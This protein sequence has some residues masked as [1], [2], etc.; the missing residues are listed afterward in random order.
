M[1]ASTHFSEYVRVSP[2]PVRPAVLPHPPPV[3]RLP[4]FDA[5]SIEDHLQPCL[6][7]MTSAA[8]GEPET[9]GEEDENIWQSLLG[10]AAHT[11]LTESTVV[12]LGTVRWSR[13]RLS[14]SLRKE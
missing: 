5:T 10:K 1:L 8:A 4:G 2:P 11:A 13:R 6:Q 12:I 3:P 14:P 9:K 7:A